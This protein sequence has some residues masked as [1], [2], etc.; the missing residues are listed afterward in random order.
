MEG[1]NEFLKAGGKKFH[2]IPC[3]NEREDWIKALTAL[4][5]THLQGWPTGSHPD[6]TAQSLS[7]L[8]AKALGAER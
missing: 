8:R 7:A 6:E 4:A 2:C 5:T 3:L 1:K